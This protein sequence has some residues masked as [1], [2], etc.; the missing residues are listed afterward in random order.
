MDK[1][2][3]MKLSTE[4]AVILFLMGNRPES[5]IESQIVANKAHTCSFFYSPYTRATV[6]LS[7]NQTSPERVSAR[8]TRA[9]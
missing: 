5:R 1:A 7:D 6:T 3:F 8:N 4:V 2:I 9:I